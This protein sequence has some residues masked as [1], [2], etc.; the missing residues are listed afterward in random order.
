MKARIKKNDLKI[1][2]TDYRYF[3][4]G[5]QKHVQEHLVPS[6]DLLEFL[7]RKRKG[8]DTGWRVFPRYS[9]TIELLKDFRND[10][11]KAR[12]KFIWGTTFNPNTDDLETFWRRLKNQL[13]KE[14]PETRS[15]IIKQVRSKIK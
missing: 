5:E 12:D 1:K 7:A 3:E 4:N 15:R 13:E 2:R 10:A 11:G 9:I 14:K 8:S 6:K